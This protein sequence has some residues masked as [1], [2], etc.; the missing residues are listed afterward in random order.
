[1][2]LVTMWCLSGRGM[3]VAAYDGGSGGGGPSNSLL[4]W[5]EKVLKN[6]LLQFPRNKEA[7][8]L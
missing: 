4:C 5:F 2:C 7:Y 6:C 3:F 8:E 1:V